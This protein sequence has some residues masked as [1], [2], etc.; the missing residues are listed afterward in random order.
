MRRRLLGG[1]IV[2][3]ALC[4]VVRDGL[5]RRLWRLGVLIG[6]PRVIAGHVVGI[7]IVRH[8][9][10]SYPRPITRGIARA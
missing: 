8:R 2:G 6:R 1:G 9:S 4:R 7:A 10:S 5:L 3:A